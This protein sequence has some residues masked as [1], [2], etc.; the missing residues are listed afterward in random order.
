MEGQFNEKGRYV[1]E[2]VTHDDRTYSTLMHLSILA[3]S[4]LPVIAFAIPLVMWLVKKDESAYIDDHGR[5]AVNFQISLGLYNIIASILIFVLIGIP[6]LIAL[7]IFSIVVMIFA[8][9]AA[10]RGEL[11]RYPVTIRFLN[12]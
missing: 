10:N 1:V 12:D 2:N 9:M 5:E 8:A 7:Q 11:Y 6:L 4:L 3:H